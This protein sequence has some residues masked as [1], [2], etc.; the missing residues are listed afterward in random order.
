[1]NLNLQRGTITD[2]NGEFIIPVRF[3]DTLFISS[4]QFE[5]K[6]I[7]ITQEILSQKRLVIQL[8]TAINELKTVN[9]SDVDLSGR[10]AKD[11]HQ[12]DVKPYFDQTNV[13]FGPTPKKR[14]S[15]LR[16]LQGAGGFGLGGLISLLSGQK[17]MLKKIYKISVMEGRVKKAQ[18]RFPVTFYIEQ[19]DIK[20]IQ[21]DD[22][23]YFVYENDVEALRLSVEADDLKLMQ[24]LKMEAQT[25]K[26]H[27]MTTD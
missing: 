5:H 26:E 20:A 18:V 1:M 24:F 19:L 11:A 25:Y 23:C 17:K 13:G 16:A 2:D 9:I 12:V 14:S 3:E 15:E 21:I 8:K 4:I 6:E 7:K 10:L 22:F 27:L